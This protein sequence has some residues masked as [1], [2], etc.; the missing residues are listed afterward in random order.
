M[1]GLSTSRE[2]VAA[3]LPPKSAASQ[4]DKGLR[5]SR[6]EGPGSWSEEQA[7]AYPLKG[8]GCSAETLELNL[9]GASFPL[10]LNKVT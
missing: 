8:Q 9:A 5:H 7:L 6:T 2:G 1:D 10:E 3:C 4:A